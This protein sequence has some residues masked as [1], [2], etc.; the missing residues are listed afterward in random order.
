M[1]ATAVAAPSDSPRPIRS[2]PRLATS[3]VTQAPATTLLVK[4]TMLAAVVRSA[5]KAPDQSRGAER[6]SG[7]RPFSAEK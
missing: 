3:K 4:A 7:Q 6:L 1:S 5:M 2:L